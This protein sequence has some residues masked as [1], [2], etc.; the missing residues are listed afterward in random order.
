[1]SDPNERI[2]ALLSAEIDG[3][4]T[5]DERAELDAASRGP[6]TGSRARL[7]ERRVT[8]ARVD[9]TLRAF[10]AG[11][12]L[13]EAEVDAGWHAIESRIGAAGAPRRRSVAAIGWLAAAAAAAI[14]WWVGVDGWRST[15]REATGE[16]EAPVI[17]RRTPSVPEIA[18]LDPSLADELELSLGYGDEAAYLPGVP[19]ADFEIIDQLELLDLLIARPGSDAASGGRG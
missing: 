4:L 13:D 11:E 5:A 17:V 3:E 2:D 10:A 1:M 9:E 16:E 15:A 19:A 7:A 8:L 18:P 6:E 14:A 12:V